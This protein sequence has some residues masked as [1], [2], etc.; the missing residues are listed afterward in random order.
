MGA[1][2]VPKAYTKIVFNER[3][4]ND[5]AHLTMLLCLP[6]RARA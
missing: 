5:H 3:G 2:N 4:G 6:R 1:R